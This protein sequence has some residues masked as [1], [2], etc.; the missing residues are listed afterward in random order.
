MYILMKLYY[1][2]A[3][4]TNTNIIKTTLAYQQ[5][6]MVFVMSKTVFCA[7]QHP[8]H[9]NRI[10]YLTSGMFYYPRFTLNLGT[11]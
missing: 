1:V 4:F 3:G 5:N 8:R 9:L 7:V 10:N 6:S 2:L 11:F